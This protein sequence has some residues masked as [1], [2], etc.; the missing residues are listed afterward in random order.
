MILTFEPT[1]PNQPRM[2][3]I[4]PALTL[5]LRIKTLEALIGNESQDRRSILTKNGIEDEG[6]EEDRRKSILERATVIN[7]NLRDSVK[8]DQA[9]LNFL[10]SCE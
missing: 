8:G 10:N 4:D 3:K 6:Q 1:L 7:Q 9:V 5:S 2:S